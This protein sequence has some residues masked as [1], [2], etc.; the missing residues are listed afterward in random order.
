[1]RYLLLFLALAAPARAQ[2]IEA[3]QRAFAVCRGCHQV[4]PNAK[5]A[6][7]PSLNGLLG[8]KAGTYPDYKYSDANR[9]SELIWD[10]PTLEAYLAKPAA[11]MPGSKMVF[12]GVTDPQK[13]KDIIAYLSQY[14]E[15]TP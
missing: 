3:G 7:G 2:D 12:A 10:A 6:I 11:M 14:G 9:T 4:G 5:H 15:K 8:R 1:M 13:V